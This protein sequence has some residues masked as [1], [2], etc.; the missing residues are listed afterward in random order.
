MK[1]SG[2]YK[3]TNIV[4]LKFYVGRSINVTRRL[5]QHLWDLR[6]N[7]HSNPKL[8]NSFN[9]Y[10]ESNFTF[11]L[12]CRAS[13]DCL[14]E[15]EQ[16]A[17]DEGIQTG[18]CF[19]INTNA[20]Y[21]GVSGRI[22]TDEQINNIKLGQEKSSAFQRTSFKNQSKEQRELALSKARSKE[23]RQKAVTTRKLNGF[24]IIEHFKESREHRR[25][26]AIERT[27]LAI[28]WVMETR[29]SMSKANKKFKINQR[30]WSQVIPL[31]EDKTGRIF[32]L[33]KKATAEKNHR[34]SGKVI[35][36]MGE[37]ESIKIASQETGIPYSTIARLC[38]N[39]INGWKYQKE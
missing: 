15:L 25:N 32:D 37:F 24:D 36:L 33:P 20:E 11:E 28:E 35:G 6:A 38:R 2:I 8:Q 17:I 1:I 26:L 19:N 16:L 30:M 31:W 34:F 10:G 4:N 5:K 21:G 27:I 7:R 12:C 13:S 3:I 29:Q 22:W 9:K 39:S 23:A 14:I 18:R